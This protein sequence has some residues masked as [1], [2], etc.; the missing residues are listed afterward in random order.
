MI[1]DQ[2]TRAL[3]REFRE[4]P[5]TDII[6][7]AITLGDKTIATTH[8]GPFEAVILHHI[9]R[10]TPKMPVICVD[11]GYNTAATYEFARKL[12]ERLQLD[13][14]YY[15]PRVTRA[16]RNAV[17]GGMPTIEEGDAH[18]LFTEEVKL[19]PFARAFAEHQPDIWLTAIRQEQTAYRASLDIFTADN[20]TGSLR[21]APFFYWSE[22]DMR[23]YLAVNDLPDIN[24]YFDPTKVLNKRECGLHLPGNTSS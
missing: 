19:E 7:K 2:Q 23:D 6:K 9:F 5:A 8:F 14:H 20:K 16:R 17:L 15:T 18:Q 24:D 10:L 11:H 13:V 21:V 3:N 1:S 12:T 4:A 22:A